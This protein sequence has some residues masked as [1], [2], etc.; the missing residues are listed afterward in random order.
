MRLRGWQLI[1]MLAAAAFGIAFIAGIGGITGEM[2]LASWGQGQLPM[3]PVMAL[4]LMVMA[5]LLVAIEKNL[6]LL[7]NVEVQ[8]GKFSVGSVDKDPALRLKVSKVSLALLPKH[9]I[10]A[11][12][13]AG[14]MTAGVMLA[15]T[16][17]TK[18]P[19]LG[20]LP[21]SGI[22]LP[23]SLFC[24]ILLFLASTAAT[25]QRI[26]ALMVIQIANL[27]V[28]ITALS[29]LVGH[30]LDTASPLLMGLGVMSSSSAGMPLP[31]SVALLCLGAG[32][33][34]NAGRDIFL[35]VPVR[36]FSSFGAVALLLVCFA[37]MPILLGWLASS[38]EWDD[39]YGRGSALALLVVANIFLQLP[40]LLH[41][42]RRLFFKEFQLKQAANSLKE[43]LSQKEELAERLRE[44]SR[45]DPLT[46]LHN[47]RAF[48]E[49]LKRSWRRGMRTG[50][51]LSLLYVDI[52][53]FKG[54][55]D[56]YG[57]PA[58]DACLVAI[59]DILRQVVGREGDVAVR[60]GGE[61][62]VLLLPE[63]AREG[64]IAVTQRF[65]AHLADRAIPHAASP[66]AAILTVSLGVA[67]QVPN[68]SDSPESLVARADKALYR[69][70]QSG[71]NCT[72]V[73]PQS[74]AADECATIKATSSV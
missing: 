3:Q 48:E 65:H 60:L 64:A 43:A 33:M 32:F 55:N 71:R 15:M 59:A 23:H 73:D 8:G 37:G 34:V 74:A 36:Q 19:P 11:A 14:L 38:L 24:M 30:L 21:A 42:A 50:Q 12:S 67:T 52:D 39:R 49:E 2:I 25:Y 18:L 22:P 16:P 62:F 63:T 72:F 61:E 56:H 17:G 70:K 28:L 40:V 58:G 41:V 7:V 46:G 27:V 26:S 35:A 69:A 20:Y 31:T 1:S 68:R 9:L 10:R 44:L 6:S 66:V 47:R 54:Y 51:P 5:L 57:H 53:H 4:L 13:L 29:A 45:R